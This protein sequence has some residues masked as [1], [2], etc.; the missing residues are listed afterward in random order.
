MQGNPTGKVK[1]RKRAIPEGLSS[2]DAKVLTKVKRRAYRLDQSM[3]IL[4][5]K[6]GWSSIIGIV[7]GFG[8]AMDMFMALMVI[9]TAKK[10]NLDEGTL[11]RMYVNVAIDFLI[12]LVPFL[13]DFA[14]MLFRCNTKNAV[15]LEKMLVKRAEAATKAG[16]NT[17][18]SGGVR[19]Q[20]DPVRHPEPS[21]QQ[22]QNVRHGDA[23]EGLPP[24]RYE[25]AARG[26]TNT[27]TTTG[28]GD[29]NAAPGQTV[30]GQTARKS[31]W[32]SLKGEKSKNTQSDAE[33]G[34]AQGQL[35]EARVV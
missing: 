5:L 18:T 33:R 15:L 31:W 16:G 13:G 27:T 20:A 10:A 26:R 24:P 25:E 9:N 2:H 22:Q 1:K 14:D 35:S 21:R 32:Q 6:V 3:N 23:N 4:G 17:G 34:E 12:G 30:S 19:Q 29:G 8:D 11:N 7:P 28:N